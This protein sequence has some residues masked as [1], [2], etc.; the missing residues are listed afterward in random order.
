MILTASIVFPHQLF[1]LNP[2][3]VAKRQLYLVEE[4]LYFNQYKFHKQKLVLHRASMKFYEAYLQ[5]NK[6]SITYIDATEELSDI[7]KLLTALADQKV[8]EIHFTDVTDN[9]LRNRIYDTCKKYKIKCVEY[10]TPNFTN[11]M[12][13]VKLYFD[14]KKKYFQTAFYIE[15]RKQRRILLDASGGAEGGRWTYDAENRLKFPNKEKAPVINFPIEN[16]FVEQ[17]KKYVENNFS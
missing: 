7:R 4:Y 12:D 1:K 2:V 5:Q 15:Q 3:V 8:T 17:A 6:I 14:K 13:D 10:P 9:W 16:G 11:T